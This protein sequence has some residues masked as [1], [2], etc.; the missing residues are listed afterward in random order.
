VGVRLKIMNRYKGSA[1]VIADGQAFNIT[2]L[3]WREREGH[4][5]G[6][7]GEAIADLPTLNGFAT[8]QRIRLRLPDG[9]EATAQA[10]PPQ[11][12]V[13]QTGQDFRSALVGDGPPFF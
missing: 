10:I 11:G 4:H 13:S 3:L 8:G 6:W 12:T 5:E 2:V 7:S 1:T 9:R